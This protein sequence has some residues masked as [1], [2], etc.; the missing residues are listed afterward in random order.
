MNAERKITI[1]PES[2]FYLIDGVGK[3]TSLHYLMR[4]KEIEAVCYCP[5]DS[6]E[7]A[8]VAFDA[9]ERIPPAQPLYHYISGYTAK[10]GGIEV[11]ERTY[12][13]E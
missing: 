13:N 8:L 2:G 6:E 7:D 4:E 10:V 1:I 3:V 11:G 12:Q 5:F 9:G